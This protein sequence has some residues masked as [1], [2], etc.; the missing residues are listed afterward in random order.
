MKSS[1]MQSNYITVS[2]AKVLQDEV[3]YLWETERPRVCQGVA[4]AAAEGDRSENA[5]YIYGKKRMREID[6]RLR[7]LSDRIEKNVIVDVTT[8]KS[9]KVYFGSV[10]DLEADDGRPTT[11]QIVGPDE[12]DHAQGKISMDSPVGKALLGKRVDDEITVHRPKG[13][14]HYT[15]TNIAAPKT[16]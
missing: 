6:Q 5:E 8:I 4:D 13:T 12:S 1:L 3:D 7:Y 10:V 14:I 9:D 2:G 16:T 11:Y 15:I